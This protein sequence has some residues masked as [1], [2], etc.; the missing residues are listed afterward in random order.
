MPHRR[1]RLL[2][3]AELPVVI[4]IAPALL[5]P[6]PARLGVLAV[7]PVLW[8][9]ARVVTGHTL[10]PT[11][12]NTAIQALLIMVGVSLVATPDLQFSLGK[13]SGVIL[14][15]LFFWAVARWL[16]TPQRLHTAATVFLLAGTGLALIGLLGVV[17]SNKLAALSAITSRLPLRIRGVPGAEDGFNPN[18]VSGCLVLFLPFQFALV[19]TGVRH[20]LE[21]Y[22]RNPWS[23]RWPVVAQL[24]LIVVTGGT[25]LLMQSRGAWV[26]L[27]VAGLAFMLWHSR[28]TRLTAAVGAGAVAMLIVC[29]GSAIEVDRVVG[30]SG[31]GINDTVSG[32]SEIWTR[33]IYDIEDE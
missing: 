20:A 16:T 2:V 9:A 13:V 10:P 1:T 25:L 22:S 8:L 26:G 15:A 19:A 23:S 7:V 28:W 17:D 33:A 5:F 6:T 14:G 29:F 30:R 11:P 31:A 32:R 27:L 18:A 4:L 12:M 21:S 24:A 3:A